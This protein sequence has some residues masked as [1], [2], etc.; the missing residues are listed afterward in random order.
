[1]IL[2]EKVGEDEYILDTSKLK[3]IDFPFY[4]PYHRTAYCVPAD[5]SVYLPIRFKFENKGRGDGMAAI[6]AKLVLPEDGNITVRAGIS[7]K[8]ILAAMVNAAEE[9]TSLFSQAVI[10]KTMKLAADSIYAGLETMDCGLVVD[11]ISRNYPAFLFSKKNG[12]IGIAKSVMEEADDDSLT[13][14]LKGANGPFLQE[15]H[16]QKDLTVEVVLLDENGEKKLASE[17]IVKAVNGNDVAIQ[18]SKNAFVQQN[19]VLECK[20]IYKQ[21]RDNLMNYFLD[22]EEQERSDDNLGFEELFAENQ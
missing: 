3:D 9:D 11:K 12:L 18:K 7:Y 17:G 21:Y 19:K 14:T 1:M 16:S 2:K 6:S 20:C 22:K 8:N 5:K 13:I 10:A 15:F 4:T